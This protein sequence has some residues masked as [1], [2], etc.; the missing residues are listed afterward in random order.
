MYIDLYK[1]SGSVFRRK[2]DGITRQAH[3]PRILFNNISV[4]NQAREEE[5]EI[6]VCKMRQSNVRRPLG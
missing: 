6:V 4:S 1:E 3:M 2:D 5:E